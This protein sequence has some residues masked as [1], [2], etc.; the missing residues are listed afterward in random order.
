[1]ATLL[2][3]FRPCILFLFFSL[4]CEHFQG[5]LFNVN[6]LILVPGLVGKWSV[7]QDGKETSI[8]KISVTE[9]TK[10][11]LLEVEGDLDRSHLRFAWIEGRYIGEYHD[12]SE[13]G[14]ESAA[15]HIFELITDPSG[16]KALLGGEITKAM[17][18]KHKLPARQHTAYGNKQPSYFLS[19]S[20]A[21]NL[22]AVRSLVQDPEFFPKQD[23]KKAMFLTKTETPD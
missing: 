6:A 3:T 18:T 8:V 2:R 14:E 10:T 17:V 1:M 5:R 23:L 22:A 4:S 9:E 21:E 16:W 12:L 11:Y 13:N 7:K 15:G 19:G 20:R